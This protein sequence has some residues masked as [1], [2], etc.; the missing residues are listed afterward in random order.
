MEDED[1][2]FETGG[3]RALH[4]EAVEEEWHLRIGDAEIEDGPAKARRGKLEPL[5]SVSIG[6]LPTAGPAEGDDAGGGDGE[7]AARA[8]RVA[9]HPHANDRYAPIT[10]EALD[11]GKI[12]VRNIT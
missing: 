2:L 8:R 10:E 11:N 1:D 4:E 9:P 6:W 7:R 12:L 5:S 3:R